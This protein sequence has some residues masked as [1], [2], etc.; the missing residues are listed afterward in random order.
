[1][2]QI[3]GFS[4]VQTLGGGTLGGGCVQHL[5]VAILDV[6]RGA[7]VRLTTSDWSMDVEEFTELQRVLGK[8]CKKYDKVTKVLDGK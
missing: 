7:F 2:L 8:Y 3:D 5:D 6:G 1:M 4:L